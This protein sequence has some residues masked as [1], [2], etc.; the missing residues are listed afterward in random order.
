MFTAAPKLTKPS[1]RARLSRESFNVLVKELQGL[2]LKVDLLADNEIVDAEHV[3]AQN[4]KEEA[5]SLP[6][7][8]NEPAAPDAALLEESV[9]EDMLNI[10]DD[11]GISVT[12]VEGEIEDLENQTIEEEA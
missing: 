7:S 6:E 8:T 11:S 5:K 9:A 10:S 3:L 2:G 1:S 4:I 12:D